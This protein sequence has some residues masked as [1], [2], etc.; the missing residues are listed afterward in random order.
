VERPPRSDFDYNWLEMKAGRVRIVLISAFFS[1]F[2]V[3]SCGSSETPAPTETAEVKT[4]APTRFIPSPTP[5]V[6]PVDLSADMPVAPGGTHTC[7]LTVG[8][9]VLCWGNNRFGQLGNGSTVN[10]TIPVPASRLTGGVR[11]LASGWS[12]TCALRSD[13]GLYCWGTNTKGQLGDATFVES[14]SPVAVYGLQE[15]V[16]AVIAGHRHTCAL[17]ESGAVKCWGENA[18]GGVGDGSNANRSSPVDVPGL[19][20][21]VKA[22]EAGAGHTCAVLEDGTVQC[23]G[24]NPNGQLGNGTEIDSSLPI[25]VTGLPGKAEAIAAGDQH[26]C[27]LIADGSIVCW[28][29]NASGQLGNGSRLHTA[30]PVKVNRLSS[31]AVRISAGGAHTCA[32]LEDG[33]VECWGDDQS[34]QLGDGGKDNQTEPVVVSGLKG[35][36]ERIAAGASHT[37]AG[38]IDGRILC[39]GWNTEGQL[40][41]GTAQGRRLPSAV[42]GFADGT[43]AVAVGWSNTCALQ[44]L[45]GGVK[46]WGLNSTGQLGNGAPADSSSP[47]DV[48]GLE[49]GRISIAVGGGHACAVSGTGG[50]KCWGRNDHGQLGNGTDANQRTPVDV[51][52]LPEEVVAVA[53][54]KDHTC[55][56]T[57]GGGVKCWGSNEFGQLGNGSAADSSKPVEVE[58][59]S[60]GVSDISAGGSHTCALG[61]N[62]GMKCWGSNKYGQLGDGTLADRSTPVD[63][64][65]LTADVNSISAGGY[66]TC[67]IVTGA[68]L[69]CW[70]WNSYGQLGDSTT[71]DR[72]GPTEVKWLDGTAGFAAAGYDFTCALMRLG[73]L[74]CWGNN[75]FGQLGDGTTDVHPTPVDVKGLKYK[76]LFLSAGYYSAC[77]VAVDGRM[78]CWGNNL[79]GQL[80]N[81]ATTNSGVPVDV[82]GLE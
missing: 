51:A 6:P 37:C 23:W 62:G 67:A 65:G 29:A 77:A 71:T 73:N 52:G 53:A 68:V 35:G 5:T 11:S 17:M 14:R 26:T 63:V 10:S 76:V 21:G 78:K 22:L 16:K 54:G 80:G 56:L 43:A 18:S 30:I 28:G 74:R 57:A 40:G 69:E 25:A 60:R 9:G 50:V 31:P 1:G 41:D 81:G 33:E 47:V 42:S 79:Y 24:W 66:H 39:W 55:A 61:R 2:F 36:V 46:C 3:V 4:P 44:L 27:A 82:V 32:L 34:G 12:H 70:G 13:G 48:S 72:S 64:N 75:E 20:G 8:G 15:G 19:S 38:M 7:A 45:T 49:S 59:L 58:G